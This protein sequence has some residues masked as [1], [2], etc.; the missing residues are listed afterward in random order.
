MNS[1][2]FNCQLLTVRWVLIYRL[3]SWVI[4][5]CTYR[6][7]HRSRYEGNGKCRFS[8]V[9]S[10]TQQALALLIVVPI[11]GWEGH[12]SEKCGPQTPPQRQPAFF[13]HCRA[14]A[15]SQL[16]VRLFLRLQLCTDQLQRADHCR[17]THWHTRRKRRE[18]GSKYKRIFSCC[19]TEKGNNHTFAE[20]TKH[21]W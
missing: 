10:F 16:P 2:I 6:A 14:D 20:K 21:T 18:K 13:L 12:V 3:K 9:I 8:G 17:R 4:C 11:H 19:W 7:R 1:D 5:K 15:V